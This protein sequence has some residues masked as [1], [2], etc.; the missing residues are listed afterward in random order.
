LIG[1]GILAALNALWCALHALADAA[2][3]PGPETTGVWSLKVALAWLPMALLLARWA[4]LDAQVLRGQR[5]SLIT[6]VA[7]VLVACI[8]IEW[9]LG[10]ALA[11]AGVLPE[12]PGLGWVIVQRLPLVALALL[13]LA[14]L[15]RGSE[16]VQ[17]PRPGESPVVTGPS[18]DERGPDVAAPPTLAVPTRSGVRQV[19]LDQIERLVARGNYVEVH[20]A[21]GPVGLVRETLESQARRLAAHGI[22]RVH[23]SCLVNLRAVVARQA[24]GVLLLGSGHRVRVGRTW[25]AALDAATLPAAPVRT[26]AEPPEA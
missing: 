14:W 2:P 17:P 6:P 9:L 24:G 26:G 18:S 1:V 13:P 7:V 20:V 4:Q 10:W 21:T 11:M 12:D 15:L 8:V 25:R 19:P 22:V 16:P 3:L 5:R 23:R